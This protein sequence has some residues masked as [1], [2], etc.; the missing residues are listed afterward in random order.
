M[1]VVYKQ[2]T[3]MWR[4]QLVVWLSITALTFVWVDG[5]EEMFSCIVDRICD[6]LKQNPG[7]VAVY[8]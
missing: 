4:W 5:E 3:H 8:R 1:F 6:K 7:I 2:L